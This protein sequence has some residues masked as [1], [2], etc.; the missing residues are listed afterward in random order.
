MG[1]TTISMT[2]LERLQK[3][4]PTAKVTR[5]VSTTRIEGMD[6]ILS[7]LKSISSQRDAE[8]AAAISKLADAIMSKDDVEDKGNMEEISRITDAIVKSR[9]PVPYTIAHIERDE[10]GRISGAVISPV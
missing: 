7:E 9:T 8:L 4:D 1:K 10:H 2:D 3:R 6:K 5:E